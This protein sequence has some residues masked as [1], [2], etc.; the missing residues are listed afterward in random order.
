[1]ADYHFDRVVDLIKEEEAN[2][3]SK[4]WCGGSKYCDKKALF[5]P[6]TVIENPSQSNRIMTEELF[7]PILPIISYTNFD[8]E[9]IEQNILERGKPLA[10]YYFGRASDAQYKA[11]GARTSSGALVLNELIAQATCSDF[12]FGGVGES[13]MGR[14]GGKYGF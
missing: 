6:P 13:G 7:C 11:L 4:T 14:V 5:V 1:M 9:V 2:P 8:K 10:I 3:K 12:G